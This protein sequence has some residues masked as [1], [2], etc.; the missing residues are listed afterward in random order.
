M[1][2]P[3]HGDP[4]SENGKRN[5]D[6]LVIKKRWY[7]WAMK[8]SVQ[9]TNLALLTRSRKCESKTQLSVC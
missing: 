6:K 2:E 9:L 8:R 5:S 1:R 3:G 7:C 4:E